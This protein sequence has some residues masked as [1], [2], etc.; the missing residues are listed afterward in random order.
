[1]EDD[2]STIPATAVVASS[3]KQQFR[4]STDDVE[5]LVDILVK[6]GARNGL[7]SALLAK[8]T[9]DLN[10]ARKK[11]VSRRRAEINMKFIFLFVFI[12]TCHRS[13]SENKIR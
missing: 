10:D 3:K 1:M 8:V 12:D 11:P 9:K 13:A 6:Y 4:W 7:K 2:V 5:L